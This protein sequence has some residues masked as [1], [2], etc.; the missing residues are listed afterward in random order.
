MK[1]HIKTHIM[2]PDEPHLTKPRPL[3][4]A[5]KATQATLINQVP[6]FKGIL[7]T[8]VISLPHKWT[9]P[10]STLFSQKWCYILQT[11]LHCVEQE[12]TT[13]D[14]RW[15]RERERERQRERQT[16]RQKERQRE[17]CST[18][19]LVG[20]LDS[21]SSTF[22]LIQTMYL[23]TTVRNIQYQGNW[24]NPNSLKHLKH[25]NS[26]FPLHNLC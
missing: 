21:S 11:I 9:L 18:S 8:S 23:N 24:M 12:S 26:L 20:L 19:E 7:T 25:Q 1:P 22:W 5:P 3:H 2:C 15:E 6:T 14:Q 4:P 13:K 16:K 17:T 10:F